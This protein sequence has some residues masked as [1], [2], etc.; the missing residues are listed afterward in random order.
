MTKNPRSEER[1]LYHVYD[2]LSRGERAFDQEIE[3]ATFVNATARRC[4]ARWIVDFRVVPAVES[5][6]SDRCGFTGSTKKMD[7]RGTR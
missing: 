2:R 7:R 3:A 6:H 5:L 1:G 4:E